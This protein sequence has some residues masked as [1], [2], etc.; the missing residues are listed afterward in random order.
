[1]SADT[2]LES[3]HLLLRPIDVGDADC[4]FEL[5]SDPEVRRHVHAGP[6]D[7]IRIRDVVLPRMLEFGFWAAEQKP[8]MDFVGWFQF[9]MKKAR[10]SDA[11]E[12]GFRLRRS[13]WGHGLATE[14]GN[15]LLGRAFS[16]TPVQEVV[17]QTLVANAASQRVLEK[18]GF[19]RTSTFLYE[20]PASA[21]IED[22]ERSLLTYG[23]AL[24]RERWRVQETER[25]RL[26]NRGTGEEVTTEPTLRV[27]TQHDT[28]FLYDLLKASLGPY[29][30]QVYGPWNEEEQRGRFFDATTPG[31]HQIV[32]LGGASIGCL[33]VQRNPD[34]FKL[35]RVFLLPEYQNLGIGT[36]LVEDLLREAQGAELP[37]TLQVFKVNP[38][39]T[40]YER[41]GFVLTGETETHVLMKHDG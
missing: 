18:L 34:A 14:G 29:I 26:Q 41:L 16:S 36:R 3:E 32:E 28:E 33:K 23:Y 7:P 8:T 6:P 24:T 19:Q 11:T 17:A 38:A 13:V 15:A 22:P 10:A 30:I 12:L 40:L 20:P 9:D 27:S 21:V 25:M 31:T 4:I 5:D 1:M 37:V 39:R 35:D 2:T